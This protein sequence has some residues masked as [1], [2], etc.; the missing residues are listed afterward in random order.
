MRKIL[1][2]FSITLAQRDAILKA[3][4]GHVRGKGYVVATFENK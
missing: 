4:D 3:A 1:Q 2:A